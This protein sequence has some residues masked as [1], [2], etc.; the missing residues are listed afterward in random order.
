MCAW[1]ATLLHRYLEIGLGSPI[2]DFYEM[3]S[4]IKLEG[5]KTMY[6]LTTIIITLLCLYAIASAADYHVDAVNGDDGNTGSVAEEAWK[7]ITHAIENAEAGEEDPAVIYIAS[8]TYN[9]E[10]GETFPITLR[11]NMQLMGTDPEITIIDGA[12]G[13]IS[14]IICAGVQNVVIKGLKVIGGEG[15]QIPDIG[16]GG[17]GI[18]IESATILVEDCIFSNNSANYGGGLMILKSTGDIV[19][20][21]VENNYTVPPTESG[22]GGL[23]WG[24]GFY[25]E[26]QNNLNFSNCTI[27][28]NK[29]DVAGGMVFRTNSEGTIDNCEFTKNSSGYGA[30]I[31]V[32]YQTTL[33]IISTKFIEN[34]SENSGGALYVNQ[35]ATVNVTGCYFELNKSGYGGAAVVLQDAKLIL[36]NTEFNNNEAETGYNKGGIGGAVYVTYSSKLT[37]QNCLLTNNKAYYGGGFFVEDGNASIE[38]CTFSKNNA[39]SS[40]GGLYVSNRSKI[41]INNSDFTSNEA[42]LGGGIFLTE[43]SELDVMNS[44]FQNNT[45]RM[46]SGTGG[47]GGG[48]ECRSH[49]DLKLV[50]CLLMDNTADIK[51]GGI[52]HELGGKSDVVCCTFLGNDI[53]TDNISSSEVKSSIFW[54]MDV[55]PFQGSVNA[56]YSNIEG[57]Y[58]GEG[59]IDEEPMFVSGPRGDYYL[60]C[61][62]AG[63]DCSSPCIDAGSSE[64]I[65]GFNHSDYVTRCD[66]VVDIG[67]ADMG[68]HYMPNI[69]FGLNISPVKFSYEADDE[70]T[71]SMD[72]LTAPIETVSDVYLLLMTPEGKFLPGLSWSG[73]IKP[74][75]AG[76]TLPPDLQIETSTLFT[77]TIPADNPP[78]DE[79]GWYTFYIASIKPGTLDFIS[80]IASAAFEVK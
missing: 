19:N 26:D 78:I 69:N 40:G 4:K 16:T 24:G 1:T 66:G 57:G 60:S 52:H 47:L 20:C 55:N 29:A 28:N 11:D 48:I 77:F 75:A 3:D 44:L 37:A 72:L 7:T 61:E 63:N 58:E 74:L 21:I 65:E 33:D 27:R 30:A 68:F 79:P 39:D 12:G 41:E 38:G 64:E 71:L 34:V 35:D 8:A 13:G 73:A 54:N 56:I 70:I 67:V 17:G 45:A 49:G 14:V 5:G 46:D 15:F 22:S 6:R 2:S 18:F 80:N 53:Y 76:I 10:L 32:T 62:A 9:M 25:C 51:G 23:G 59:N 42:S 50:N 43:F 31:N 36:N